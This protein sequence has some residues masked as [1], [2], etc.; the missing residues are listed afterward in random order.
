METF[1]VQSKSSLPNF[2]LEQNMRQA[3]DSVTL[4]VVITVFLLVTAD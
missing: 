3:S 4:V 1:L 2:F